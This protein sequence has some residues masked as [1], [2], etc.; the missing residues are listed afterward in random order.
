M[1]TNDKLLDELVASH[2]ADKGLL[3]FKS[4]TEQANMTIERLVVPQSSSFEI[5][6]T[7]KLS[8]K[9]QERAV[10]KLVD[11]TPDWLSLS[12]EEQHEAIKAVL[13]LESVAHYLYDE[14][15]IREDCTM[16]ENG[17]DE[18]GNIVLD[19]FYI[20]ESYSKDIIEQLKTAK[21]IK[22]HQKDAKVIPFKKKAGH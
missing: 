1:T 3:V 7:Y 6:E 20:T 2:E 19:T 8:K 14:G 4:V 22:Q 16:Y 10:H 13:T 12:E 18:D 17:F 21:E 15:T 9:L 11:R 5:L